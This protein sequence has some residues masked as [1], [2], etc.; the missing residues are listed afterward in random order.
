VLDERI[1]V[2]D[3]QRE[4]FDA[5]NAQ[6]AAMSAGASGDFIGYESAVPI[7]HVEFSDSFGEDLARLTYRR[8]L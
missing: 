8:C 2:R 1:N 7:D 3:G 4:I 5:Q 6:I